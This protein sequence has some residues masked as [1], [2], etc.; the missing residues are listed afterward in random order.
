MK[1]KQ[2]TSPRLENIIDTVQSMCLQPAMQVKG[3]LIFLVYERLL[4][5]QG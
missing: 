5:M 3:Q 1:L 2:K 4:K